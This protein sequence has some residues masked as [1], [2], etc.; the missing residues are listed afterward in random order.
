MSDKIER[1]I[2]A[3]RKKILEEAIRGNLVPQNPEDEPA[4][5][6]LQRIEAERER[7]IK[8]KKIKRPKSVSKIVRRDGLIEMLMRLFCPYLL[9]M[10]YYVR[11]VVDDCSGV[12]ARMC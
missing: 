4:S 10:S 8:E 12:F 9:K 11:A 5:V 3:L 6:L 2:D 7:L 1:I